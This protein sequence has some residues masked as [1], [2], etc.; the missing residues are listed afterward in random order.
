M[1]TTNRENLRDLEI[2]AA[3]AEYYT[4]EELAYFEAKTSDEDIRR[5]VE[6][7]EAMLALE[8]VEN[9]EN[10]FTIFAKKVVA[11]FNTFCEC[12]NSAFAYD[13]RAENEK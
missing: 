3:L 11:S 10:I 6:E 13:L 1:K 5:E 7:F 12:L 8:E 4:A 2:R 9:K